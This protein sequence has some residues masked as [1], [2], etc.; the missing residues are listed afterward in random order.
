MAR[1]E[2]PRVQ[3]AQPRKSN[4][5]KEKPQTASKAATVKK[6]E[7]E[8]MEEPVSDNVDTFREEKSKVS[9]KKNLMQTDKVKKTT[10]GLVDK[11]VASKF[12][13]TP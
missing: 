13:K 1:D 7:P 6:S 11:K 3:T 4:Q 8:F 5:I 10:G 9:Q 12:D 2:Q